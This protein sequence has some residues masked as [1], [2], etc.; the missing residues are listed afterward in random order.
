MPA[1]TDWAASTLVS[2]QPSTVEQPST[3]EPMPTTED[4]AVFPTRTPGGG[5]QYVVSADTPLLLSSRS[6]DDHTEITFYGSGTIAELGGGNLVLPNLVITGEADIVGS[7]LVLPGQLRLE[8]NG[9]LQ[10]DDGGLI[11]LRNSTEITFVG[12]G[13]ELPFLSLGDIG[14]T[15][16]VIPALVINIDVAGRDFS[17]YSRPVISG[18]DISNCEEWIAAVTLNDTE[19]FEVVCESSTVSGG[20]LQADNTETQLVVK[21]KTGEEEEESKI[22]WVLIAIIAGAAVVVCVAIVL[23][24]YLYNRKRPIAIDDGLE[25][26]DGCAVV[27]REELVEEIMEEEEEVDEEEEKG[28]EERPIDVRNL[29]EIYYVPEGKVGEA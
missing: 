15:Y 1:S 10:P 2:E 17:G 7:N 22:N 27:A 11:E 6:E 19:H 25:V 5:E 28:E 26:P 12:K 24:C 21:S 29:P 16:S 20:R 23:G 8:R 9:K 3:T 4:E 13:D 14:S 18:R